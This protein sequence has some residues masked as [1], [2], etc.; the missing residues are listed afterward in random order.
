MLSTDKKLR[1][2]NPCL[3]DERIRVLAE[4]H[5]GLTRLVQYLPSERDQNVVFESDDGSSKFV[6]KISNIDEEEQ[7]IDMIVRLVDHL[8]HPSK[9]HPNRQGQLFFRH[10]KHLVRLVSYL[11]GRTLARCSH[12]DKRFYRNLGVHLAKLDASLDRFSH[13]AANRSIYWDIVNGPSIIDKYLEEIDDAGRRS[14]VDNV[15][16][17]WIELVLPKV[18]SLRKSIIHNDAN[19]HNILIIDEDQFDLIDFGDACLT[20]TVAELAIACAY[21]MLN[22]EKPFDIARLI[23]QGYHETNRLNSSEQEV[24]VDFILMRLSM[25]VA[26]S[27]HERSIEP[28]NQYLFVSERDIWTL[29][30]YFSRHDRRQLDL[31]FS[32]FFDSTFDSSNCI[33]S[34]QLGENDKP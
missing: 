17:D 4:N 22:Q 23:I 34:H 19:D 1:E 10:E 24:L 8:N 28:D 29:L 20:F 31:M 30:D 2:S 26:I 33:D 5:Y 14:M 11:P 13:P 12:L 32:S 15:R 7:V 16:R 27:C 18:D 9:T 25:S 6:L 21:S 3:T